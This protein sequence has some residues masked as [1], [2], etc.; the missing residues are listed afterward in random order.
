MATLSPRGP[1]SCDP[2]IEKLERSLARLAAEVPRSYRVAVAF[3]GGI[4]ST[5]LLTSLRGLGFGE[6]LRA[7]HVDHG[8]HPDSAEWS[9]HCRTIADDLGVPLE[10]LDVAVDRASGLGIEAAAREARYAAFAG[11]V[12]EAEVLVTA[13][14]GGDQLETILLRVLRGSGVDGLTAIAELGA[15]GAGYLFRP[16]LEFSRAEIEDAATRWGLAWLEDPSNDEL[17]R[18]RNFLRHVIVP[19]LQRRWPAATRSAERLARNMADA[20]QALAELAELDSAGRAASGAIPLDGLRALGPARRRNL[21]RHLIGV[22]G[23][24][25][26]DARQL[27]ELERA[28][29]VERPDARTAVRWAGAE[30]RVYNGRLYLREHAGDADAP[31]AAT[32]AV[33]RP[34]T[35]IGSLELVPTSGPGLPETWARA[36]L[37]IRFR[38]GGERFKPLGGRHHRTLKQCFQEARIVPWMRARIP[39]LYHADSLVAVADLWLSDDA[40]RSAGAEER[41]R[42]VWRNRPPIY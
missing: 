14:H 12:G 7:V 25:V 2:F 28:L 36:G 4:D 15:L 8:L 31:G 22:R 32:L 24:P 27:A 41:W 40:A 6:R 29:A 34:W 13:H 17:A 42:V 5:V 23:V 21:L 35:A 26:P 20:K 30:A 33:G 37:E 1:A 18:D 38:R 11:A 39:L 10:T 19:R 3:S 9:A 16:L